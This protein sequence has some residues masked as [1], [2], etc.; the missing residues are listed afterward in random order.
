MNI[1]MYKIIVKMISIINF[2]ITNRQ[3]TFNQ[4]KIVLNVKMNIF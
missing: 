3:L 2:A 4:I 1:H